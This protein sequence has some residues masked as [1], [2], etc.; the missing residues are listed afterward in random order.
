MLP[1]EKI[2]KCKWKPTKEEAL[3]FISEFVSGTAFEFVK[4]Q[5][6]LSGTKTQG[7]GVF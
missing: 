4:C 3:S 2:T 6:M 7:H 1:T 5:I